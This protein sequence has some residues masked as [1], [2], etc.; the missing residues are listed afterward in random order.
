MVRRAGSSLRGKCKPQIPKASG[1][2][3]PACDGARA[4]AS[5][6]SRP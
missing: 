6:I 5:D 4:L 2:D 1:C 3:L